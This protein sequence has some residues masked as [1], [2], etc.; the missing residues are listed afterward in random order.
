MKKKKT[1]TKGGGL[2]AMLG[3]LANQGFA[4]LSMLIL[5]R[6]ISRE[7]YGMWALYLTVLSMAEMARAGFVQN[8]L[9]SFVHASPEEDRRIIGSAYLLNISLGI[10]I[11]GIF[12]L[13]AQPLAIWWS[14]P[15]LPALTAWYGI[16]MLALGGLRFL[17]YVQIARQDFRGVLL[18]NL[19]YGGGQCVVMAIWWIIGFSPELYML[20]WLQ[21]AA[22]AIGAAVVWV[23]RRSLFAMTKP[24][25]AWLKK[26]ANYG[27]FVFGTNLGSMLL[28][29]VDVMMIGFFMGPAAVAPYNVALR[30]TSYLEVPLRGLATAIFP[31]MG[32]AWKEEGPQAV[33]R[34]HEK[35]TAE[36]LALTLP[37][38]IAIGL[39]AGPVIRIVAG[40]GYEDAVLILRVLLL[41]ALI[42]P[43]G[44]MFGT[45]LD[46]IG[47]PE[48]NFR[49][50]MLG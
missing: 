48:L 43:W 13:L 16:F 22:A 20:I 7:E 12:M 27:R 23:T 10:L 9:V 40:P 38:C 30:M 15:A 5:L 1:S 45:T 29:R 34:L 41:F 36:M 19:I 25:V 33:A 32:K 2:L 35:T 18:G 3:Q 50:V 14:A 31:K 26:L 49:Y 39:A 8:G 42:K 21:A 47:K 4:L 28:Q 11:W 6:L 37:V 24:S 46:A 44:R 17:E